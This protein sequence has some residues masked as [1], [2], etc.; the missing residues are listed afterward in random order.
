MSMK[1][2]TG[3]ITKAATES[4]NDG[5]FVLNEGTPDR[6]GDIIE[7]KGWM[8]D[9]FVKNPIALWMHD[10]EKPIGVWENVHV[11]GKQL[12]GSLRLGNT[13]L[14][15][16]AKQLLDDGIL[17]AVSVGFRP[18]DYDPIDKDDPWGAWHIK[19][20]LLL[21]TSLVSVP[22]HPNALRISK[23]L[24]LSREERELVF[25]ASTFASQIDPEVREKAINPAVLR[26]TK[27]LE[28]AR[29]TLRIKS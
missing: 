5:T 20:A 27:S 22:A 23:S 11:K 2:T 8:L 13:N 3:Y 15:R 29:N 14:A 25:G 1:Y 10:H 19:S 7:A 12:I 16:M 4:D 18:I 24:G 26:A 28:A 17:K 9:D 21:E 6:V